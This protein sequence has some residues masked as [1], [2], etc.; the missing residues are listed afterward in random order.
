[1]SRRANGEGSVYLRAD[2]R[3]EGAVWAPTV[4]GRKRRLRVYGKTRAEAH[5]KLVN[6]L[7]LAQ[8]GVPA[9]DHPWKV[10]AYLAYWLTVAKPLIAPTTHALYRGLVKNYLQPGLGTKSLTSLSVV[11][12]QQFFNDQLAK[13]V[14]VRTVQKQRVVLSAAL[15]QA[16]REELVVRNVARS[17]RLPG[18]K[19]QPITPWTADQLTQ[20]LAAAR[21]DPLYVAFLM[22]GMY[23]L[24]SGEVR[25]LRWSDIEWDTNRI[26][27]RQQVQRYDG[28]IR[29]SP[30]K[31]RASRRDLPL[32]ASVREAL[33]DKMAYDLP[34]T[35]DSLIFITR[36]DNPI[37][38]GNILRSFRRISVSIGLPAIRL[39][40][41]RHTA[42]T[43]LKNDGV[44]DRD[45]QL[46]LGHESILTTQMLYQHADLTG[47]RQGLEKI[48][49]R[50]LT[51]AAVADGSRQTETHHRYFR[52]AGVTD[53][54]GRSAI[55]APL[56][57]HVFSS[58]LDRGTNPLTDVKLLARARY[59][60]AVIGG[61]A[62]MF[63]RQADTD[64]PVSS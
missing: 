52:S 43:L 33:I 26:L 64:T 35:N 3:W 37:E 23:G 5:A 24:R 29:A 12:V 2:G 13:D 30:L 46:I 11:T 62:V 53:N 36:N 4:S 16:M 22:V 21:S 19:R 45:I 42:A 60:T 50:T 55:L 7:K 28:A 41:L 51:P 20:F 15:S 34:P 54:F 27:V 40:H 47:Q 44:P 1:M 38:T 32:L 59:L 9:P 48:E 18:S 61:A 10:G 57:G 8:D 6:A 49:K 58:T 63:C 56:D 14:S 31:T 25:G 17:V 39:H